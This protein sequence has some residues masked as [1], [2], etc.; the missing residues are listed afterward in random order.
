[1]FTKIAVATDGSSL[2]EK[3]VRIAAELAAKC[4][5]DLTILHVL[6]HGEPPAALRRM[7]EVEHMVSNQP[8]VQE[9]LGRLSGD[10]PGQL[11]IATVDVERHRFDH[12]IIEAIGEKIVERAKSD[13]M[14]SAI[15][16]VD[17]KILEGDAADEILRAIENLDIDLLVLGTRGLSPLKGLVMGSV[18]QA[19]SQK[20]HC[21]CLIVK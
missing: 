5:S 16:A 20:A 21:N 1:M 8:R 3:A 17:G 7:A 15:S 9:V 4:G 2:A 18:S 12:Q 6:M 10:I 19:V 13:A 14:E 11:A